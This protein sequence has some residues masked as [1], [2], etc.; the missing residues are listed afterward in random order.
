MGSTGRYIATGVAAVL[1]LVPITGEDGKWFPTAVRRDNVTE[2]F[3]D[4]TVDFARSLWNSAVVAVLHTAGILLICS[5]SGY[6]LAR[7]P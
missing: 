4:V 1:F 5:L 6:G 7:I 2:P 3:D